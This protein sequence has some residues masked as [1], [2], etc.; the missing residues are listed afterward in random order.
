MRDHVSE[1]LFS[2]FTSSDH[3]EAIAGDLME[4]REKHGSAW[5]WRQVV[6]TM[7][8]LWRSAV[9]EGPLAAVVLAATGCALLTA[10]AFAGAAAVRLFPHL[11]GS[12]ASW[13]VL[14]F[15]W[16]GGALWIGTSLIAV[17]P[18]R[19]MAACATLAVAGEVLLI[20]V[21]MAVWRD[22]LSTDF[23]LSYTTGLL[24]PAMLVLGGAIARRRTIAR[25]IRA[26]EQGR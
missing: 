10:P 13:I 7:L 23:L 24:V 25:G 20:G 19:G 6:G 12:L 2:L 22:P 11:M 1:M 5:F 18:R 9:M 8:A 26:V 15:F 16:W 21:G 17:A 14:A 4:E 3:A